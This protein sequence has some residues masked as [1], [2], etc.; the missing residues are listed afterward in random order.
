MNETPIIHRHPSCSLTPKVAEDENECDLVFDG[1]LPCIGPKDYSDKDYSYEDGEWSDDEIIDNNLVLQP[2]S[3][4]TEWKSAKGS[5]YF[6]LCQCVHSDGKTLIGSKRIYFCNTPP[7]ENDAWQIKK[8][9]GSNYVVYSYP[10][11]DD[12]PSAIEEIE[13]YKQ[14]IADDP[15]DTE[16]HYNLGNAYRKLKRYD[17]TI[18]AYKQAIRIKSDYAQAYFDLGVTYLMK[19]DK[20]SVR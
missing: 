2:V 10:G 13:S 3:R 20:D 17:E 8:K 12:E 16:A 11:L 4:L 9:S 7:P 19:G 14:E 15:D 1:G 18:E 6:V 5:G